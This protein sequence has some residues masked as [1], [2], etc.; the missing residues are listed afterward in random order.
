[1]PLTPDKLD[2]RVV[3]VTFKFGDDDM[4]IKY[5]P[6]EFSM[7]KQQSALKAIE[8]VKE[9]NAIADDPKSDPRDVAAAKAE[10]ETLDASA[11][12]WVAQILVWW[13]YV[14][15]FNEDGTPGPMVPITPERISQEMETHTDLVTACMAAAAEDYN[16]G[17]PNGTASSSR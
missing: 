11:S 6:R 16:K 17:K 10:A 4:S 3:T 1:M 9:L 5:R 14:E 2:T 13:D 7:D 8:R 12:A 15:Y